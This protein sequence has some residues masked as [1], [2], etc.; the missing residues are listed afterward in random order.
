MCVY[1]VCAL[2]VSMLSVR[3]VPFKKRQLW[4]LSFR[5]PL[6]SPYFFCW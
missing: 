5:F 2:L 1:V 6:Y 4:P 3:I